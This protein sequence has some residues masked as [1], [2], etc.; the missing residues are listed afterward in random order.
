[1]QRQAL[2]LPSFTRHGPF[3]PYPGKLVN[4]DDLNGVQRAALAT[5][6]LALMSDVLIDNLRAEGDVIVDGP[7]AAN[8]LFAPLLASM[9]RSQRV[10]AAPARAGGACAACYLVGFEPPTT[11]QPAPIA[12]LQVAGLDAYRLRWRDLLPGKSP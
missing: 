6:Y 8:P 1:L 3:S 12:P 9:R 4:A 10:F 7:L 5:L 2:A 11:P